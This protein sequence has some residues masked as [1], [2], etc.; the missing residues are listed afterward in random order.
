MVVGARR[1]NSRSRSSRERI[2]RAA[3]ELFAENG[4]DG[5][6][7]RAIADRA[8]ITVAGLYAHFPAKERLFSAVALQALA[9]SPLSGMTEEVPEPEAIARQLIAMYGSSEQRLTRRLAIELTRAA[10][11]QPEVAESLRQFYDNV[12]AALIPAFERGQRV[13]S[14]SVNESPGD[15]ARFLLILLMGLTHIDALDPM[16][17]ETEGWQESVLRCGL[18]GLGMDPRR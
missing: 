16:L 11:A 7:V 18:A 17:V 10:V 13:G 14:V 2:I 4:Y 3:T 1:L 12:R 15:L 6:S 9:S 5:T 8:G